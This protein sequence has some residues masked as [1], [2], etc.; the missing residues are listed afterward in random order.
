MNKKRGRGSQG[1]VTPPAK[2]CYRARGAQ[3]GDESLYEAD[4]RL[5]MS[6]I[7]PVRLTLGRTNLGGRSVGPP[8]WPGLVSLDP[9][10]AQRRCRIANYVPGRILA[11][12]D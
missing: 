4:D 1:P 11:W 7:N 10:K 5:T 9:E 2:V 3:H 8:R 12:T 6:T